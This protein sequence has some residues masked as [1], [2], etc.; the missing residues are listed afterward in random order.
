MLNY[1][2][3]FGT[4]VQGCGAEL[5]RAEPNPSIY[6]FLP[7]PPPPL[8]LLALACARAPALLCKCTGHYPR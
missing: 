8:S 3:G 5:A 1:S 2:S 4:R 6:D 7:P